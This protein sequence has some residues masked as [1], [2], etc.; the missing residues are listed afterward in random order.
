[1][2]SHR[3]IANNIYKILHKKLINIKC[4]QRQ[5]NLCSCAMPEVDKWTCIYHL[6]NNC[7]VQPYTSDLQHYP[8]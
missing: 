2:Q 3:I 8:F 4:V 6:F 7:S 5:A 1:M